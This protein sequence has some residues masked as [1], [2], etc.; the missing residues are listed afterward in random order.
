MF[1]GRILLAYIEQ[2]LVPSSWPRDVVVLDNLAVHKQPA[3]RAAIDG[4]GVHV[5]FLPPYNPNFNPIEQAFAKAF[6]RAARLR[7]FDLA[8]LRLS[9]RCNSCEKRSN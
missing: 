5:R 3:V 8:T 7:S 4:T 2:S 1:V 6:L 9:P